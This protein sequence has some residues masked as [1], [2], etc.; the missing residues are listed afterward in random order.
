MQT[1]IQEPSSWKYPTRG[2]AIR[3]FLTCWLVYSAHFTTNIVREVYLTLSIGDHA[4]FQVNEYAN[5]HPDIFEKEGYGWH[6]GSNPGVSMLAAVPYAVLRPL[7]DRI[8]DRVRQSREA[9]PSS[10]PPEYDSPW[11]MARQFFRESWERGFDIKFGLASVVTQWF[12]MAP[13]S[14]LAVVLMFYLMR[15]LFRSDRTALWLS[16]LYAFATPVFFRTGFLNHNLMLGHIAFAGFLAIWNP[17][18]L[19]CLS[20]KTAYLLAGI[21]GGTAV[22]FD[23]S[24]SILLLALFF[25]GLAKEYM[26]ADA[27]S[28]IRHGFWY[29]LG[30]LPPVLLLWF[31]QWQS[32]GNPF[33]P[34]QHWMPPVEWIGDGYQ[35]FTLPQLELFTMLGFDY[36][37]GL[38]VVC[39]LMLL[40]L[41]LPFFRNR[42]P[43]VLPR[44][45]LYTLL[46]TF[47]GLWLFFSGVSY[48]RLQFNTGIRYLAPIFPFLFV[49]AAAMLVKLPSRIIYF[50]VLF[51]VVI[52]WPLAMYR[53]VERG[54]GILD[55]V[56]SVFTS[57]FQ[58]PVLTLMSRMSGPWSE[59]FTN[60]Y[61]SIPVLLLLGFII[62]GI[63]YPF[64]GSK[65]AKA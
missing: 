31:Y 4:S 61:S 58:L 63:W 47:I 7:T 24:G 57:G 10:E 17:W 44:F 8:V 46:L 35:G 25:Y 39:P 32:F 43:D 12:C 62:V 49:P 23:Y 16:L 11:P 41:V 5:M 2:I 45:E 65:G 34:G 64:S 3:L 38:F 21:A 55:P 14:A 40:A 1:A 26:R 53:D 9:D 18:N 6:I 33:Y 20:R 13:S 19:E 56:I 22:L 27:G 29:F 37:F 54:L 59:H 42:T 28:M 36:R 15:N 50:I 52:A 30:T 48:T 51:S 60:G